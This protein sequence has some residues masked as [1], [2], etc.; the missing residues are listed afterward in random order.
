LRNQPNLTLGFLVLFCF[1]FLFFVFA[2]AKT[3]IEGILKIDP[4]ER[5]TTK[6][7]LGHE[8]LNN[9][10]DKAWAGQAGV[11][12]G[13][14]QVGGTTLDESVIEGMESLGFD[15][16]HL[17]SSL[18]SCQ[19]DQL[20]ALFFLL[21]KQ[22]TASSLPFTGDRYHPKV[23]RGSGEKDVSKQVQSSMEKSPEK[24]EPKHISLLT[25]VCLFFFLSFLSF[26]FAV[27]CLDV[28]G[29]N[30]STLPILVIERRR[31]SERRECLAK[32]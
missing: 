8:W 19:P 23:P 1:V 16:E 30:F 14:D 10:E 27:C 18:N 6:Q 22:K 3:L 7:I 4:K 26:L 9:E 12:E 13:F 24:S 2:G 25:K 15:I 5:L 29:P 11:E 17:R 20:S 21:R 32:D 31:R 28:F